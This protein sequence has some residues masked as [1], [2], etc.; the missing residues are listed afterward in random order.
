MISYGALAIAALLVCVNAETEPCSKQMESEMKCILSVVTTPEAQKLK[1]RVKS[2]MQTCAPTIPESCHAE[3]EAA[4]ECTTTIFKNA[5]TDVDFQASKKLSEPAVDQCFVTNP[6]DVKKAFM[7]LFAPHFGPKKGGSH[8]HGHKKH[9]N[10]TSSS[11]EK[12]SGEKLSS[13]SGESKSNETAA[14]G[15]SEQKHRGGKRHGGR[16][17]SSGGRSGRGRPCRPVRH[18]G[19][20]NAT[21]SSSAQSK[22]SSR[23]NNTSSIGSSSKGKTSG[24]KSSASGAKSSGDSKGKKS[25]GNSASSG[26]KKTSGGKSATSGGKSNSGGKSSSQ[27]KHGKRGGKSGGGSKERGHHDRHQR[28]ECRKTKEQMKCVKHELKKLVN[29]SALVDSINTLVNQKKK[30]KQL[31]TWSCT[32]GKCPKKE[33]C[34][35]KA[36]KPCRTVFMQK[37]KTCLAAK[38][39]T[40]PPFM[41]KDHTKMLTTPLPVLA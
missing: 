6:P 22:S 3:M 7:E 36:T 14:S 20:K 8:G 33:K 23:E 5:D 4:H 40:L 38:G 18:H 29:D 10:A 35:M 21:A 25:S 39:F 11:E 30:C 26:A 32:V 41:L 31:V 12:T 17:S 1:D 13:K 34:V 9:R 27:E 19:H 15:S 2:I 16:S 37:L 24:G 28:P